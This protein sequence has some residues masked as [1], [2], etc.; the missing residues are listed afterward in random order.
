M[1]LPKCLTKVRDINLVQTVCV[2]VGILSSSPLCPL[3]AQAVCSSAGFDAAQP[4]PASRS[5]C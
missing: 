4:A 3:F 2:S 1:L 5:L